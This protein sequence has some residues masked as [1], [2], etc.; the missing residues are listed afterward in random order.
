MAITLFKDLSFIIEG[1]HME[2][3]GKASSEIELQASGEA[4]CNRMVTEERFKNRG[5]EG[6]AACASSDLLK[7][8]WK[9]DQN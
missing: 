1:Q 2:R 4:C 3:W 7:R 8:N 5:L 6:G 9:D